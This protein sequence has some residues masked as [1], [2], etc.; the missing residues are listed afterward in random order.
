M[1][2]NSLFFVWAS[3]VVRRRGFDK[4]ESDGVKFIALIF[5]PVREF[6]LPNS[7]GWKICNLNLLQYIVKGCE[8]L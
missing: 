6:V 1:V 7:Q 2:N 3:E 5:N 4:R 8:S